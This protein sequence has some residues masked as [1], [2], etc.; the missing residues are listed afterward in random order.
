MAEHREIKK[1]HVELPTPAWVA[2][3]EAKQA[4]LVKSG[5]IADEQQDFARYLGVDPAIW[6][7]IRAVKEPGKRLRGS[8]YITQISRK[9]GIPTPTEMGLSDEDRDALD[10][11]RVVRAGNPDVYRELMGRFAKAKE[12]I[13]EIYRDYDEFE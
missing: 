10:L 9:V 8:K 2:L 11:L 1:G 12:L 5:T 7:R 4:E 13:Y 3:V 6:S